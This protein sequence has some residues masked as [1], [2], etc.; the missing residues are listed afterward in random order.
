MPDF[1]AVPVIC[2]PTGS[3]KTAISLEFAR[4]RAIEIVSAD[5]R[6]VYRHLNIGTA[7]PGSNEQAIAP[8]HCIDLI[9]PGE[10]YSAYQYLAD[11]EASIRTIFEQQ[12]LPVVV[13]GTGL[14]IQA[15]IDGV[16]EMDDPDPTLRER[17]E[18][19][20]EELGPDQMHARLTSID[21]HEAARIHPN[22][23]VRVIRA[24]EIFEATGICKS[25]LLQSGRYRKLEYKFDIYCLL[26]PRAEL[27]RAIEAR[28]DRM[29]S[30]GLLEELQALIAAGRGEAIRRSKVIGYAEL[31][32][33]VENKVAVEAA[34]ATI[35]QN[36]R[37]FAKRQTTWFRHQLEGLFFDDSATLLHDISV[38]HA[39]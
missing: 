34:V 35:K 36:S 22:N 27:Y 24:L 2:G 6:Q 18:A 31:L 16:V 1:P 11:A 4:H 20:M 26:P 15:L 21:P 32:G 39:R 33:V 29:M 7:K 37:R 23:R 25:K 12:R 30:D 5:S 10:R 17:L 9:E 28:V 14:Y 13:G 8:V 19:E 38:N 3:G